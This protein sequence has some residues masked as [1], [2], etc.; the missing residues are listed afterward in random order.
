VPPDAG[1]FT[2]VSVTAAPRMPRTDRSK[3][4]FRRDNSSVGTRR[5]RPSPC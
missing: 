2:A 5:W 3:S 1:L 4:Q